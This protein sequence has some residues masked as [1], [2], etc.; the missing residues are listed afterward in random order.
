MIKIRR[1]NFS[2]MAQRYR[3]ADAIIVS[4][5]KS[6]R[7]WLRVL[8]Q[9]YFCAVA[10]REFALDDREADSIGMPRIL[11]THDLWEHLALSRFK[12]RVRGKF[13]IPNRESRGKRIVLLARDPRDVIVSLFFQ[14]TRRDR[15]YHG[16]LSDMIRDTKFGIALI[17]EIM[18]TW[19][20]EWG[21]RSHVNFVRYEDF[22]QDAEQTFRD[23]LAFL[24]CNSIDASA[25]A[26]SLELASFE[27]MQAMEKNGRFG[28]GILSPGDVKDPQS[29]KV[30]EGIV[31]GHKIYLDRDDLLF[32]ERA[33][34][35]LDA[36]YGYR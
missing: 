25:V 2:S 15:R 34:T 17:V 5:P 12:D 13:L 6:G 20:V 29:F 4:I 10:G 9:S 8:L 24:G 1:W 30:R 27:N 33:M 31:G 26:H 3:R 7:T 18:N 36:R 21:G 16:T 14:L 35:R 28:A 19:M 23:V 11:Y 32:C 22:R